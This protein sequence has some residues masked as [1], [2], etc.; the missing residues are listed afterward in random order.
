MILFIVTAV[1]CWLEIGFLGAL[2]YRG[3]WKRFYYEHA[4]VG[5]GWEDTSLELFI[6]L[7]G[8]IGLLVVIT[9]SLVEYKKI[10]L[11][12]TIPEEIR[13]PTEEKNLL[14]RIKESLDI[15]TSTTLLTEINWLE[16]RK[17]K[18]AR[19]LAKRVFI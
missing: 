2:M 15:E 13:H 6:F 7:T 5:W 11:A 8:P 10:H 19:Q 18:V 4:Y 12:F 1:V 17:R 9:M 3:Y 14:D 16:N